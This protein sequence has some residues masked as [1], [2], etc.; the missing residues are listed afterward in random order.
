MLPFKYIYT[1]KQ[2]NPRFINNE[3]TPAQGKR[4]ALQKVGRERERESAGE[5]LEA[6]NKQCLPQPGTMIIIWLEVFQEPYGSK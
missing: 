6:Y 5:N 4:F 1:Q 2:Q 3:I